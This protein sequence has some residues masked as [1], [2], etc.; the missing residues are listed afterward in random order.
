MAGRLDRGEVPARAFDRIAVAQ[1]NIGDEIAIAAFLGHA[2][3][4][5][6][7]AAR[8][9]RPI[10]I[11]FSTRRALQRGR[12]RRMVEMGVR[13][14]DMG[15]G[16]ALERALQRVDVLRKVGAGIDQRHLAAANDVGARAL[17]GEGA[18]IARDDPAD[19]RA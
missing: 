1:L 11:G 8:A 13:H 10:G 15:D 9:M 16:F 18:R 12:C 4:T 2:A 7:G 3:D 5:L 6:L 14:E 17:E 19:E